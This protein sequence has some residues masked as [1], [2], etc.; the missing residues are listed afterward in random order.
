MLSVGIDVAEERKGLDLVALDRHREVVTSVRRATVAQVA[1]TVAELRP[2]VVC[3][4][5]PPA[6]A[7]EGRSRTA[8]RSLRPFG[9]TAF[10]TPTDP[11]DHSFYRWMRVGFAIFDAVAV[12]HP[13]YRG[14]PVRGSAAEVFPEATAVLLE[15]RLRPSAETKIRFRRGVLERHG[16]DTSVLRSIDAVDAALAAL[17]G[18]L[19]LEGEHSMVGDPTEGV[20]LLP[21]PNLPATRLTRLPPTR[22][23]IAHRLA[24]RAGRSSRAFDRVL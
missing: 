24:S 11:G 2:D 15:G 6:W 18:I 5:S 7:A 17:T 20:I 3:I 19:A 14:G 23:D 13:R 12:S 4:D 1:A 21:V 9:I 16:V 8:E 10:S 22:D